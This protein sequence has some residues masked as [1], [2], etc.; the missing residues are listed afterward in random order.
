MRAFVSRLIAAHSAE[1]W[2]RS[3]IGSAPGLTWREEKIIVVG[4]GSTDGTLAGARQFESNEVRVM[5]QPNQGAA[6]ARVPSAG[7]MAN[8]AELKDDLKNTNTWES[9]RSDSLQ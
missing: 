7:D 9:W 5:T 2:V 6:A 3:A 4:R 1:E 8:P